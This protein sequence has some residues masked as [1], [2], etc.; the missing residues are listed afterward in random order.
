M[1]KIWKKSILLSSG[2]KVSINNWTINVEWSKGILNMNYNSNVNIDIN[3]SEIIFSVSSLS[4]RNLRWLTRTLVNNLVLWVTE[5]FTKKLLVLGVWYTAKLSKP[6]ELELSLWYS[7]KIHFQ[8]PDDIKCSMEKDSKGSDIIIL[9]SIDKQLLGQI[10]SDIRNLR[11][12]E[13]YK[14]KWIRYIDEIVKL[15]AWKAAKK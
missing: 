13:P 9:N 11:K 6:N 5:W 1:S 2:V 15:K 8:L 10:A 3:E 4:D 7:H 12:P 14:G